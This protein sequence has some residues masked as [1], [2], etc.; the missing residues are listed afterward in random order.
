MYIHRDICGIF[1]ELPCPQNTNRVV[2]VGVTNVYS[3]VFGGKQFVEPGAVRTQG[4]G[5]GACTVRA[6]AAA[7]ATGAARR[8]AKLEI[9]GT[10]HSP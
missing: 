5:V 10:S 8:G 9:V 2:E 6:T 3:L 4:L 7:V 1:R